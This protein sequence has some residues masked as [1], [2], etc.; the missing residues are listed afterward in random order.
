M[1]IHHHLSGSLFLKVQKEYKHSTPP[2]NLTMLF[3]YMHQL[4]MLLQTTS[5]FIRMLRTKMQYFDAFENAF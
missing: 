2:N 5:Q 1:S 4:L 3:V